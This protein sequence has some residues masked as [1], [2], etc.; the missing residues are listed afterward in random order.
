MKE[1]E[2][3]GLRKTRNTLSKAWTEVVVLLPSPETAKVDS[4]ID[5]LK[6]GGLSRRL[7]GGPRDTEEGDGVV[8]NRVEAR[9]P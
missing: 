1:R 4:K 7:A 5:V 2:R 9:N 3:E 6:A 8:R